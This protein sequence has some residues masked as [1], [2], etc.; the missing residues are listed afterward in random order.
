MKFRF[1]IGASY[2]SGGHLIPLKHAPF[3]ATPT[4]RRVLPK[5]PLEPSMDL[6][7]KKL[8]QPENKT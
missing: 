2:V 6:E 8:E 1:G 5:K 3:T 7:K 4:P